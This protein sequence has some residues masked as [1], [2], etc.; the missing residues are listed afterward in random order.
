MTCVRL[1]C[2]KWPTEYFDTVFVSNV[3]IVTHIL[4]WYYF[5]I[6]WEF[7]V[8]LSKFHQQIFCW[9]K[10]QYFGLIC[11]IHDEMQLVCCVWRSLMC[12]F[13]LFYFAAHTVC[14]NKLL[15]S[16]K[17][18]KYPKSYLSIWATWA[19]KKN[20]FSSGLMFVFWV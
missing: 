17:K 19:K 14:K 7:R 20:Q 9:V 2:F 4:L 10:Y 6:S 13:I 18:L 11:I 16:I 1:Q 8:V 12:N 5:S 3:L 15:E